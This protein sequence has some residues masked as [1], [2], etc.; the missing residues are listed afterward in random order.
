[1]IKMEFVPHI[2]REIV[3]GPSMS[4]SK[5]CMAILCW[6]GVSISLIRLLKNRESSGQEQEVDIIHASSLTK[7]SRDKMDV[8]W[9]YNR[10][11][12][13]IDPHVNWVVTMSC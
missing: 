4:Q 11:Y 13:V 9:L 6:K 8:T 1:M 3:L 5:K 10:L 7:L 12:R 2:C